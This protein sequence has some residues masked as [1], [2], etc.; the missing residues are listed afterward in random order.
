VSQNFL[1]VEMKLRS[2][3]PFLE[4]KI[5]TQR[6]RR[7]YM[8]GKFAATLNYAPQNEGICGSGYTLSTSALTGVVEWA[9][10]SGTHAVGGWVGPGAD[11]DT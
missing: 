5:I 3:I 6:P 8:K 9:G 2:A 7:V 4:C 1:K 11:L 10:V